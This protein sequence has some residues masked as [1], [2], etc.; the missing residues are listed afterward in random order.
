MSAIPAGASAPQFELTGIDDG[1]Y[2]LQ[3]ALR[4]GSVLVAF[5]KISCPTCQFTFPF[6][7]RMYQT[8][9][10]G[11][12]KFWAVSQDDARDTRDFCAEYGV[13][14]TALTDE[15]G[16]PASNA[17]GLTNVPSI[18]LIGREGGVQASSVGFSRGDLEAINEL[19]AQA[20]GRAAR[21]LFRPGE[22]IP[23][24]RHG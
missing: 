5:F 17:Y 21:P 13:T 19:A 3:E 8:F 23:E 24:T 7:E 16:Y 6:L 1:R 9:G 22:V 14:F 4:E 20:G 2:S 15:D 12:L 10:G 18:F 11:K